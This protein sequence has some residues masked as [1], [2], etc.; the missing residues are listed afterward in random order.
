MKEVVQKFI[1]PESGEPYWYNPR[2]GASQW[3]KLH[4][5]TE[6]LSLKIHETEREALLAEVA[7]WK[8]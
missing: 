6:L 3:T 2:T 1:D 8:R 4:P 5:P 7:T